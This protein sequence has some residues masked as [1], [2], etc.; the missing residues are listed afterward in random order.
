MGYSIDPILV[1]KCSKILLLSN[2]IR[3][4]AGISGGPDLLFCLKIPAKFST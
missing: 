2:Q 3:A 4:A 1:L